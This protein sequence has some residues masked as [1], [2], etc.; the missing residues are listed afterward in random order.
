MAQ[1]EQLPNISKALALILSTSSKK[2]PNLPQEN[3]QGTS[4]NA[5]LTFP[6]PY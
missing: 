4:A 1:V 2:H 6:F 5:E 3:N